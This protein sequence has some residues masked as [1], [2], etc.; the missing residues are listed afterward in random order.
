M[1]SFLEQFSLD[2]PW[3][4]V[5]LMWLVIEATV[6]ICSRFLRVV[7]ISINGYPKNHCMNVDGELEHPE[8]DCP[9]DDEEPEMRPV[10]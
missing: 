2:F 8:C 10:N 3:L 4:F 9:D 1:N 7:N 6:K 5:L